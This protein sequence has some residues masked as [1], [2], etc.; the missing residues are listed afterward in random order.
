MLLASY[1]QSHSNIITCTNQ[2]IWATTLPIPIPFPAALG[3]RKQNLLASYA[4]SHTN[5]T[6]WINQQIWT[7]TSPPLYHPIP[8]WLPPPTPTPAPTPIPLLINFFPHSTWKKRSH[9][10]QYTA[11]R[12]FWSNS[13]PYATNKWER[14]VN[15]GRNIKPNNF[16][17]PTKIQPRF[18]TTSNI[19]YIA[20]ICFGSLTSLPRV[21]GPFSEAGGHRV[22]S[23]TSLP[24]ILGPFSEAGGH[25][26][27]SLT[28]LP[29]ILG[30]FSEAGGH[31]V[32]SLTSLPSILG[33]FSEAG[34]HRVG[35]LTSLPSILGPFSEAGG[36]R[37]DTMWH[38]WSK[39]LG[40]CHS[41][42]IF[43]PRLKSFWWYTDPSHRDKHF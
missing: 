27:G 24:S 22:G 26:V 9:L 13:L 43:L 18:L 14:P 20:L 23:L 39:S 1:A 12:Y 37:V 10:K 42:V 40:I 36:H 38:Q 35:S 6:T 30:P 34:G 16:N 32:G 5:I 19:H 41:V 28:S 25:R 11:S 29:S 21:L 8:P 31:R 7:T 15:A 2:Q 4:H 3:N 33:P 17:F